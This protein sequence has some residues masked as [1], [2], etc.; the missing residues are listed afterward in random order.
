MAD[1]VAQKLE[2]HLELEDKYRL[3]SLVELALVIRKVVELGFVADAPVHQRDI[4]LPCTKKS[5][6]HK[7]VRI[8]TVLSTG[9]LIHWQTTKTNVAAA[10]FEGLHREV[11]VASTADDISEAIRKM[12]TL[13][14]GSDKGPRVAKIRLPYHGERDGFEILI[15]FDQA[16][17]NGGTSLGLFVELEAKVQETEQVTPARAVLVALARL[18]LPVGR[19]PIKEGYRLMALS[20]MKG[21]ERRAFV[22]A[23]TTDEGGDQTVECEE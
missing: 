5:G 16:E 21:K 22:N 17:C 1:I 9:A 14:G 4:F 18:L 8:E 7:R 12:D 11:E 20:H 6:V 2:G 23:V 10:G 3:L 19:T 15:C 13:L